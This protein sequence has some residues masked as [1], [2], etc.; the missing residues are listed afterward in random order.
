MSFEDIEKPIVGTPRMRRGE[1]VR[2]VRNHR[3][4][5]AFMR[6]EQMRDVTTEAAEGIAKRAAR[7]TPSGRRTKR[8]SGL[9]ARVK[10]GFK[11]KRE[12]GLMKVAGNLRVK[13]MVVN[14][15]DGAALLEFGGRGLKR[16][17]MLARA[18][19]KFGDFKPE[20][21]APS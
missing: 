17:R 7:F 15:A 11:V 6:S 1:T 20:E 21:G 8:S 2:Y 4:F 10:S 9:H 13:V 14:N 3:S 18:G 5:G 19:A 12:A 16:S